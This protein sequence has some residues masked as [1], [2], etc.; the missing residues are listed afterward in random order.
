MRAERVADRVRALY[1]ERRARGLCVTCCGPLRAAYV[2][3]VACRLERADRAR[4]AYHAPSFS[5]LTGLVCVAEDAH[6]STSLHT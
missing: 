3:C 1:H 5:S 2:R 6:T 4:D